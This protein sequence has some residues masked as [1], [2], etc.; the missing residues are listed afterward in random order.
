VH[1]AR[2][3]GRHGDPSASGHPRMR[4]MRTGYRLALGVVGITVLVAIVLLIFEAVQAT[5]DANAYGQV[6]L[7]GRESVSLPQGD[8][9]IY[10]GDR[11]GRFEHSPLAVPNNL[12]LRVR[13]TNGQSLV[14]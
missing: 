1:G 10:Y 9:I 13:T 8:V 6:P 2:R 12:R 7:P 4:P 5:R 11:I 3:A 14:G